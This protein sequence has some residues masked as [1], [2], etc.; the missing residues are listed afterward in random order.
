MGYI[1]IFILR[2]DTKVKELHV[3]KTIYFGLVLIYFLLFSSYGL[4]KY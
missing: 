1:F 4:G 3:M 2:R